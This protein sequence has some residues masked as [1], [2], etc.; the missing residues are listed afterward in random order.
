MSGSQKDRRN[1]PCTKCREECA[2]QRNSKRKICR[3]RERVAKIQCV[4][5][6]GGGG[7][8]NKK[9]RGIGEMREVN[10]DRQ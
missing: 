10:K 2:R 3:P 9:E 7:V 4:C 5:V 1:R 8:G 6:N